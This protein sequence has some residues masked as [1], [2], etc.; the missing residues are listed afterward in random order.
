MNKNTI[1]AHLWVNIPEAYNR[2]GT[3][4]KFFA[5][6]EVDTILGISQSSWKQVANNK[7]FIS[8]YSRDEVLDLI[9]YYAQRQAGKTAEA[10]G[11]TSKSEKLSD[12]SL[13]G[14][15]PSLPK[16]IIDRSMSFKI[17]IEDDKFHVEVDTDLDTAMDIS[18]ALTVIAQELHSSM[19]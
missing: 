18:E 4:D 3:K 14:I 1:P 8:P 5:S 16:E 7:W 12:S 15:L 9:S 17:H 13:Y 10:D 6:D 2:L 11:K 19:L